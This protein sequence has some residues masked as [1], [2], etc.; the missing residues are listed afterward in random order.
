MTQYEFL[1]RLWKDV[2]RDG[3][4]GEWIDSA[5]KRAARSKAVGDRRLGEL[6]KGLIDKGAS[7][8]EIIELLEFDRRETVFSVIHL[9]EENGIEPEAWAGIHETF[10]TAD[11]GP[12]DE[13]DA[14][15]S[16]AQSGPVLTLKKSH[17]LAFSP[18]Q[19]RVVAS[20]GGKIWDIASG[21]E[22]AV[23]ELP[24]HTSKVAW[25]PNG[26][27]IAMLSTSGAI[28]LCDSRTGKKIAQVKMACEGRSVE[29][30]PDGKLLAAGDWNGNL[31]TWNAASGKLLNKRELGVMIDF[32]RTS[33]SEIAVIADSY[34]IGFDPTLKTE[35]W[36]AMIGNF[37]KSCLHLAGDTRQLFAWQRDQLVKLALDE[38][39]K[40]AAVKVKVGEKGYSKA[41]AV[42]PDG[43]LVCAVH[44]NEFILLDDSLQE[45]GRR[46]IEYANAATFSSDSSLIALASWN[47]GEIWRADAFP[48]EPN[49]VK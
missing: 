26:K 46:S 7:K 16:G 5:I 47:Q 2:I 42:S 17:Y 48:G 20:K 19:Q 43:R 23:C 38:P 10:D 40:I 6:L 33:P 4:D 36:R 31:F 13:P 30:S 29:F 11:P 32:V 1:E 8:Q 28:R 3:A 24:P 34:A 37:E 45:I 39:R 25:S 41:I 44:G 15:R 14:K 49:K 27:V 35:R 12:K 9:I 18:D 21:K 22:H